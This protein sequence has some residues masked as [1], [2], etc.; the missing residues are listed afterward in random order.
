MLDRSF[1]YI[2]FNVQDSRYWS[3]T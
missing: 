3:Q 1:N 2:T